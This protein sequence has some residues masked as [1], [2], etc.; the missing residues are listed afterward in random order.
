ME[1]NKKLYSDKTVLFLV[2]EKENAVEDADRL[3]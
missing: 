3:K 1:V 2:A